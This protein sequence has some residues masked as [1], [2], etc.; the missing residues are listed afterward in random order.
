[1][2]PRRRSRAARHSDEALA[3]AYSWNSG[4]EVIVNYAHKSHGLQQGE[5]ARFYKPQTKCGDV[6]DIA[7]APRPKNLEL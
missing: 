2:L 1:V 7:L 4:E 6:R 5:F 3:S